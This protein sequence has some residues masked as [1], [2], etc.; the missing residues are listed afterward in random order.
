MGT[1][2]APWYFPVNTQLKYVL[3]FDKGQRY[4]YFN[5]VLINS[6]SGNNSP[7]NNITTAIFGGASSGSAG[8]AYLWNLQIHNK[9]LTQQEVQ[10]Y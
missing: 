5:G 6:T 10:L 1:A 3:V 8:T 4:D 2:M 9:S 7:S